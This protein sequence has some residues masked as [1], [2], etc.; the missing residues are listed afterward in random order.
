MTN[1]LRKHLH[2]II[3]DIKED[4]R[5]APL[6]TVDIIQDKFDATLNP[7]EAKDFIAAMS[8]GNLAF[9]RYVGE[10]VAQVAKEI[11]GTDK[12]IALLQD[13]RGRI[14]T[15]VDALS[16]ME[17][18][19]QRMS[20]NAFDKIITPLINSGTPLTEILPILNEARKMGIDGKRSTLLWTNQLFERDGASNELTN[21]VAATLKTL[22]E[23]GV[24]F[25]LVEDATDLA[26][27]LREVLLRN[28]PVSQDNLK[29]SIENGLRSF[30][31][32]YA[33]PEGA[34]HHSDL[35]RAL[36]TK[37]R[38]L[39]FSS[40]LKQLV[41]EKIADLLTSP[42]PAEVDA[43]VDKGGKPIKPTHS[44]NRGSTN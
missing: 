14:Y 43:P 34:M 8:A 31:E 17:T 40:E 23:V 10:A 20:V 4:C 28:D 11:T 33:S 35:R 44:G 19:S 32:F 1:S 21:F 13:T 41:G 38:A 3:S 25:V 30:N 39:P 12:H 18:E 15:T 6:I 22:P 37:M 29:R 42:S 16:L 5:I 7:A 24:R 26:A 36:D 27:I 9:S 2:D